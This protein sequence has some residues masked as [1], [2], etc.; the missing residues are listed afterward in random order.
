MKKA[1]LPFISVNRRRKGTGKGQLAGK[2]LEI[3]SVPFLGETYCCLNTLV[4]YAMARNFTFLGRAV[5]GVC[6]ALGAAFVVY[7]V[8]GADRI[9]S[10]TVFAIG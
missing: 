3:S 9:L 8:F 1:F 2:R 10:T 7:V 4:Q 5:W 6:D